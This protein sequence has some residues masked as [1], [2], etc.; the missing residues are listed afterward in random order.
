MRTVHPIKVDMM[1]LLNVLGRFFS[2]QAIDEF[3]HSRMF[4]DYMN[5]RDIKI[6]S[7]YIEAPLILLEMPLE[8]VITLCLRL[9]QE[10]LDNLR[11]LQAIADNTITACLISLIFYIDEGDSSIKMFRTMKTLVSKLEASGGYLLLQSNLI[12][13]CVDKSI[14]F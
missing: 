5:R 3:N 9:E 4:T 10:I 2:D 13:A 1:L 8:K 6:E 14:R 11:K 7:Y 12:K